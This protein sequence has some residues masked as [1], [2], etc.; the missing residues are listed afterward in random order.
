[1]LDSCSNGQE[2]NCSQVAYFDFEERLGDSFDLH[3]LVSQE[4][5]Q[6]RSHSLVEEAWGIPGRGST[7]CAEEAPERPHLLPCAC[8]AGTAFL[9]GMIHSLAT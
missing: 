8:T 7:A 5:K 1:M 3:R 9:E 6:L 2:D 4:R